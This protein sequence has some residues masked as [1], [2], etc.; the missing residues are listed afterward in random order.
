MKL[1]D[2]VIRVYDD[3][4]YTHFFFLNFAFNILFGCG[5]FV[6]GLFLL[7]VFRMFSFF[8]L[9]SFND[10]IVLIVVQWDLAISCSGDVLRGVLYRL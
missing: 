2:A 9:I 8:K 4:L 10:V 7:R 1:K 6:E 5:L 3:E